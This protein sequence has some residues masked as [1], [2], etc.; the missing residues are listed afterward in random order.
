MK[1]IR[2]LSCFLL[3]GLISFH[4]LFAQEYIV[5]KDIDYTGSGNKHQMLDIYPQQNSK[6]P[7]PLIVHIHGGAFKKGR[8]GGALAHCD[9]LFRNGYVI[10]DLNYRLSTDSVFPA[11][12]YDCKTAIRYLKLHC[13]KYGIDSSR[14]GLIGESAGGYLVTMLGTTI[15]DPDFEGF[16]LGSNGTYATVQAVCDFYGPTDFSKL[17]TLVPSSCLEPLVHLGVSSP[18]SQFLGCHML[19]D[20]PDKVMRSNPL[21]YIN[22]NEPPF[23]I[24]HGADDCTVTSYQSILLHRKLDEKGVKNKL[25]ISTGAGH[26]DRFFYSPEILEQIRKFFDSILK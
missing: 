12:I 1:I 23:F 8:K 26:A 11:A 7:A 16:H 25:I 22:G 21:V 18:E 19:E 10:A 13:K 9:S 17:D 5:I 4:F 6:N 24:L 15:G 2:Y 3:P 14:I 20:C